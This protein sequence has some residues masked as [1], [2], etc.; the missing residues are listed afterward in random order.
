M[1]KDERWTNQKLKIFEHKVMNM[2]KN[3]K[4]IYN[5]HISNTKDILKLGQGICKMNH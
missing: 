4:K 5:K 3:L 1:V 2:H